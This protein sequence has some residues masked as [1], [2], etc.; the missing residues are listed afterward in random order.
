MMMNVKDRSQPLVAVVF[1][2]IF[3]D[4]SLGIVDAL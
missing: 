1:E 4:R 2:E 3:S